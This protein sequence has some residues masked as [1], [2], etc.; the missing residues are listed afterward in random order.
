LVLQTYYFA[1]LR[2]RAKNEEGGLIL[3]QFMVRNPGILGGEP[4]FRGSRV[5]FKSLTDYIEHGRTLNEFLEDLPSVAR[6]EVIAAVE[7]A[8]ISC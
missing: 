1:I 8:R 6:S 5:P 2:G 3:D 4:I 7:E